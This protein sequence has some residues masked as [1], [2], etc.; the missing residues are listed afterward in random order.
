M[1]KSE[2]VWL[3]SL[4]KI[5]NGSV[6]MPFVVIALAVLHRNDAVLAGMYNGT[7]FA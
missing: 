7:T 3:F 6:P 5:Y 2:K 1:C 4:G